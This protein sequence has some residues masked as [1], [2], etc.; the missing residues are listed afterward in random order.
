VTAV[1]SIRGATKR[2]RAVTA[3]AG[4]DLDLQPG[5]TLALVGHNGAGKTTLVKL[6]L[7]LI[8]PTEGKVRVF[9][10]DPATAEGAAVRQGLGYLPENVAF[11]A[12]MTGRELM[13]FYTRLKAAD[14]REIGGLLERV[15][16]CDA[17]DR[18]VG[19]YSKGMRQRLGL[20]Q[21]LI[22]APELMLLDEPTSGLDPASRND[23]YRMIDDLRREG[24][25]VLISTH[26]L[27]EIEAHADRI[28]V[29]HGGRLI[30]LG[31][32][33]DLRSAADLPVRVRFT[34]TPCSTG[35]LLAHLGDG[36]E[37]L[38]RDDS[39]IEIGCAPAAKAGLF[40]RLGAAWAVVEDVTLETPGLPAIYQRLVEQ[41]DRR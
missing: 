21:A 33:A 40:Q 19:T 39:M 26:A 8:A 35:R 38:E 32:L 12:A 31:T 18:R 28:A 7:G 5:E 37:I 4:V 30:A 14:R 1:A 10:C 41:E 6:I 2:Y 25:T 36:V 29:L 9:E 3:V 22:G 16:L 34:V 11:H 15:G 24:V 20:A 13:G 23:F 27:A 17:A